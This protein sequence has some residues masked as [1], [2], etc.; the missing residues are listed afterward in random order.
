MQARFS[1]A[2]PCPVCTFG[3]KG[4]SRADSGL[5]FC[6]GV[7]VEKGR[8]V[9]DFTSLGKDDNGEFC[10]FRNGDT[11]NSVHQK[12][13][14]SHNHKTK[15]DPEPLIDWTDRHQKARGRMPAPR[16]KA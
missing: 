8:K 13:T 2:K 14:G 1:S 12:A 4:C 15:P 6:R 11:K 3:T 16:L 7:D 5:H 10:V 9:N